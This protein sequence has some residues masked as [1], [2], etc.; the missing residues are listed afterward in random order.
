MQTTPISD[1]A[2]AVCRER[3]YQDRKWG[4]LKEHPHTVGEWL[5]IM[6]AELHEAK[7]AW[8]KGKGDHGALEELLQVVAVGFAAMEQHGVVERASPTVMEL[9]EAYEYEGHRCACYL[10][11][12]DAE[13]C[14]A[15]EKGVDR[16]VK[17][18]VLVTPEELAT[19]RSG[20][21]IFPL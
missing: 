17:S 1:V 20:K 14:D 21:P 2:A 13:N 12:Q 4:S 10:N 18:S 6:E 7:Q 19:L 11:K 16:V 15:F 9:W 5:L 3:D 8:C